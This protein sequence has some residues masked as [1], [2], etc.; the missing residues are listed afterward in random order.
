MVVGVGVV[1]VGKYIFCFGGENR[2]FIKVFLIDSGAY[3]FVKC[4]LGV[5]CFYFVDGGGLMYISLYLC[6]N[7]EITIGVVCWVQVNMEVG[8]DSWYVIEEQCFVVLF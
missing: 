8:G 2:C 5:I 3:F 1:S 4:W 6:V 7:K